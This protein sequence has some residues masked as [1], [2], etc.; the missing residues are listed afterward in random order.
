MCSFAEVAEFL[1][2]RMEFVAR[3]EEIMMHVAQRARGRSFG[4]RRH[5]DVSEG[6]P[7]FP[8][9]GFDLPLDRRAGE[10]RPRIPRKRLSAHDLAA[11]AAISDAS[12]YRGWIERELSI[13]LGFNVDCANPATFFNLLE[14]TT[15]RSPNRYVPL[16][17]ERR[18]MD[19][20]RHAK[21]V[22]WSRCN[23]RYIAKPRA[24]MTDVRRFLTL[25]ARSIWSIESQGDTGGK[26]AVRAGA[27]SAMLARPN[28][29]RVQERDILDEL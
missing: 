7:V 29:E 5:I 12:H 21:H 17:V 26:M 28:A 1:T 15:P 23:R 19:T 9:A 27:M 6:D 24:E 4:F 18:E 10:M 3:I 2:P 22:F 13:A 20:V 25:S 16:F 14:K 11:Y 8:P